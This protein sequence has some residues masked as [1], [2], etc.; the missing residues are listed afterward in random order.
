MTELIKLS[1]KMD[2]YT[3]KSNELLKIAIDK[4]TIT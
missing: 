4:K 2:K 1:K 3:M